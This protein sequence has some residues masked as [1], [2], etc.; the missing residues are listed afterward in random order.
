MMGRFSSIDEVNSSAAIL[1]YNI[2]GI[3]LKSQTNQGPTSTKNLKE[4]PDI[5][6]RTVLFYP[7]LPDSLLE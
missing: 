2:T 5:H 7:I 4:S 3:F 6:N 1:A